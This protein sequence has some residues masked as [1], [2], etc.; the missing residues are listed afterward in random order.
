[1]GPWSPFSILIR[2]FPTSCLAVGWLTLPA[3][4]PSGAR[5]RLSSASPYIR[6]GEPVLVISAGVKTYEPVKSPARQISTA[7]DSRQLNLRIIGGVD[8]GAS[9]REVTALPSGVESSRL[10]SPKHSRFFMWLPSNSQE[11]TGDLTPEVAND[12]N[13]RYY[14]V[15]TG[16]NPGRSLVHAA[17]AQAARSR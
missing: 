7:K 5:L 13:R 17:Q 1:M 10:S 6:T 4:S 9:S 2:R 8:A 15:V 14:R 11:R 12:L 3:W 16:F